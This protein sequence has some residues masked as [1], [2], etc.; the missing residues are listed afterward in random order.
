VSLGSRQG[1][2]SA[3]RTPPL[4]RKACRR[5]RFGHRPPARSVAQ[6]QRRVAQK[7]DLAQLIWKRPEMISHLSRPLRPQGG[8]SDLSR[9]PAGRRRGEARRTG[10]GGVDGI[11]EIAVRCLTRPE[12]P[13]PRMAGPVMLI[14][15]RGI[16]RAVQG[17]RPQ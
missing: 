7:G 8:R 1:F 2:A 13:V 17:R 12:I 4:T 11:G 6:G 9:A 10:A 15:R 3:E 14:A 16:V 5:H